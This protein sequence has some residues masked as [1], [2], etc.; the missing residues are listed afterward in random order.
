VPPLAGLHPSTFAPPCEKGRSFS[1]ACDRPV[2][3][4]AAATVKS[5]RASS[6]PS[7][8]PAR[9]AQVLASEGG[10]PRAALEWVLAAA[11]HLPPDERAALLGDLQLRAAE[12][13]GALAPA[14]PPAPRS[15]AAAGAS[16]QSRPGVCT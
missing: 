8:S 9:A 11:P 12:E 15:K 5:G 7:E 6:C 2:A 1:S 10:Q 3:D 4:S 13:A 16:S 14:T